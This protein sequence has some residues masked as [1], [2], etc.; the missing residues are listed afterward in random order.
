MKRWLERL[1]AIARVAAICGTVAW[2]VLMTSSPQVPDAA[3]PQRYAHRHDV[4]Y[5]SEGTEWTLQILLAASFTLGLVWF[6]CH[7][8]TRDMRDWIT[9]GRFRCHQRR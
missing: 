9:P 3:H 6:G 2:L 7:L 8:A 1:G 4:R 5:V